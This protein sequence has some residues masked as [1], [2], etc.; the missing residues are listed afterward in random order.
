MATD[1]E[2]REYKQ[3]LADELRDQRSEI[4]NGFDYAQRLVMLTNEINGWYDSERSF[5]DDIA[6]IHSEASEA[7]EAYRKDLGHG[8]IASELADIVVRVLDTAERHDVNLGYWLTGKM[9]EN[10]DRGYRHG[11]RKL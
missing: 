4:V 10:I 7:L 6:L 3:G 1:E 11:G 9:S 2:V 8:E 5:G